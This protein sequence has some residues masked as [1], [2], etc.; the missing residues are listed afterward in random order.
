MDVPT[1]RPLRGLLWPTVAFACAFPLLIG[2]GWWQLERLAWKEDML[3]RFDEAVNAAPVDLDEVLAAN[4][5]GENVAY[6]P[7]IFEA[8]PLSEDEIHLY[9]V[10][11]GEAGWRVIVAVET[12]SGTALL[13]DRGFVPEAMK[14]AAR[15]PFKVQTRIVGRIQLPETQAPFTPDN[16]PQRNMW[17]WRDLQAMAQVVHLQRAALAP[18]YVLLQSPAPE[19][20]WPRPEAMPE[21][22]RNQ[23]LGYALTWF[24]L[25]AA[26]AGVY[27]AFALK[28]LRVR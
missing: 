8:S 6:R 13:L 11:R 22:P 24:G 20:G 21:P 2:L 4:R 1:T 9:A 19:G 14:N 10:V 25:A 28:T 27:M 5:A 26:L 3:E 18:F 23:H 12:D 16:E 17:Y 15:P 7:A